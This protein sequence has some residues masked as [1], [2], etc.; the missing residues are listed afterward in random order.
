MSSF[1]WLELQTITNEIETLRARLSDARSKKNHV[2]ARSLE[3]EIARAEKRRTELLSHITTNV[4]NAPE[5]APQ[6]TAREDAR[7]RST[8][9]SVGDPAPAEAAANPQPASPD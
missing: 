8:A 1:E 2:R 9:T 7:S 6:M 5:S 3:E 4:A